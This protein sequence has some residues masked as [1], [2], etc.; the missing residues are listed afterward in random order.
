MPRLYKGKTPTMQKT[1]RHFFAPGRVNLIGDHTDYNGGLVFPAAL[2]MGT[3]LTVKKHDDANLCRFIS[4]NDS[5]E[6]LIR[7]EE[8]SQKRNSWVD[9]PL[10]V[11]KEFTDRGFPVS[12]LQFRYRGDLP[13]GAALSS[14]ASIEMVTAVALNTLNGSPFTMMQLVQMAQ[15]AENDFVGMNCG[16]MDQFASGFG[17]KDCAIALDCNTLEYE[18]VP[19]EMHGLKFVIANTNKKRGLV[20]SAYNQRRSECQQA[21]EIIRAHRQVDCLCQL[22]MD[23][24]DTF[25]P[26]LTG[27]V[28]KRA[29]HAVRE[30]ENVRE[31]V[32]ALKAGDM[33]RFG[34]LMNASHA[35]L[36]DDYE[37]TCPE[38]D[39]LA[40]RAQHFPGVLGSRMTGAGFG[41]CTV[42]LIADDQ[43]NA[44]IES[45]GKAYEERF[46]L[47]ADF[48]VAEIGDGAGEFI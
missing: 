8:L 28:L 3:Y 30:N 40:E 36:R 26:Y 24:F 44:F 14:S 42:T 25:A 39:F 41:G 21:L 45:L 7:K 17:K 5:A 22:T 20:D 18:H 2:N 15:H 11:V 33:V 13:I 29:R 10:G 37:V 12:A 9:Y 6:F 35:T 48:Y 46:S 34:Q 23:Q 31:A 27:N 32:T 4:E 43:V 47:R 16:I 19:L 1:E 38:L